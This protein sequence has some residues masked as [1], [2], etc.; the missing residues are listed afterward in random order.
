MA[1]MFWYGSHW[2]FWQAALMWVAVLVF[3]GLVFWA[4]YAL[5]TSARR[6]GDRDHGAS[7]ED[8]PR[9][10]LDQRLARGEIDEDEYRHLRELIDRTPASTGS[11]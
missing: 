10:I 9:R 2:M 7:R 1:M 4:V 5:V 6:S 8:D 11:R 3:W